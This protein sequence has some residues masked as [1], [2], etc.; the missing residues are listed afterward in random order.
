MINP[1]WISREDAE[2]YRYVKMFRQLTKEMDFVEALECSVNLTMYALQSTN[3]EM[4]PELVRSLIESLENL[5]SDM[6]KKERLN[7]DHNVQ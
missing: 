2:N 7:N 4:R 6:K 3:E 5:E 1:V